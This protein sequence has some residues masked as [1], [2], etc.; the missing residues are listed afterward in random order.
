MKFFRIKGGVHP[1]HH[2]STKDATTVVMGLPSKVVIPMVQHLGA[3]CQPL[4]KKGDT[5]KVGQVIGNTDAFVSAPVHASVSGTVT[6]VEPRIISGSRP[7]LCVE[8]KPDGL[9]ELDAI[10]PP[11]VTSKEDFLKAVRASGLTGLGGAGFPTHVK[12]NPP[13]DAKVDTLIINAAECEPYITS[14]YRECLEN[15][16]GIIEGIEHVLKWTGIPKAFIGI[17]DNKPDAVELLKKATMSK[18]N[19]EVVSL[20]SIYPQGA[21]KMLIY[22]LTGRQV[23]PGKL[24]ADAGCIV[25]NVTSVAFLAN[26]IKTGMP[27]IKKRITVDGSAVKYPKNVEVLIG[28]PVGE[29]FEFCGGLKEEPGKLIM[30]GPMMGVALYSLELP[31][32]K[33]TNALLALSEQEGKLPQETACIRCGRCVRAC[34]MN[35]LPLEIDRLAKASQ[36]DELNKY[37]IMDCIECGSCVFACPA[38]RLIVQSI[39]LGKDALRRASAKKQA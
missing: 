25:L 12:L 9:Q 13:K 27:L 21:E 38:K 6:A 15:T 2:K 23:P 22:A 18:P 14:D 17:E 8:I 29:V 28:T 7:I 19:I 5:V 26:Y 34:P 20:P 30:G 32:L 36:F 11:V 31:V 24:P 3:P 16:A 10:E 4:V 37:N 35:L 1:S 39:R 33:N